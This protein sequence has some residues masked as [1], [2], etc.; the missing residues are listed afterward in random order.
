[1][2]MSQYIT[3]PTHKDGNILDLVFTNNE[4]L[5][6]DSSI[7]PVLQSTS[8]HVIVMIST[9]F[10]IQNINHNDDQPETRSGFNPL[11][12]FS[13]DIEWDSVKNDLN[14]IDWRKELE[15]KDPHEI[16]KK[17]NEIC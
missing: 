2:F 1:M 15:S 11:N 6:H 16:L 12:F 5:I 17:F 7:V 10:K 3:L 13:D 9:S 8:H 4:N 14:Q